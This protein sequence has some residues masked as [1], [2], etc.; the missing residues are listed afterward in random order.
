MQIASLSAPRSG[1]SLSLIQGIAF[2]WLAQCFQTTGTMLSDKRNNAF[3]QL[4]QCSRR[5]KAMFQTAGSIALDSWEHSFGGRGTL[6]Y[7]S[8]SYALG[9]HDGN[10]YFW[11]MLICAVGRLLLTL[12]F[13]CPDFRPLRTTSM[14]RPFQVVTCDEV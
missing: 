1:F 5:S 6:L 3:K 9:N 7:E 12:T 8:Q 10:A 13:A 11:T 14:A 4:E 2:V